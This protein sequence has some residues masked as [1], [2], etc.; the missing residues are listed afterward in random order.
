[1]I[2]DWMRQPDAGTLTGASG[3]R[4]GDYLD[5]T[6]RQARET[7]KHV[8]FLEEWATQEGLLQGLDPRAK[9]L[10]GVA[11]ILI[12]TLS[13]RQPAVWSVS[14]LALV[15]AVVSRLPARVFLQ[16]VWLSVPL[17]TGLIVLPATLNL[18]TPGPAVLVLFR[19]TG[20]SL[21]AWRL[22][23]LVAIT[24][25]GLD[26]AALVVGRAGA[27]VS[28]VV[29]VTLTTR[30]PDLLRAFRDL[31]VS[32]IFVMIIE[33][34]HRYA[35][36]LVSM[37]EDVHKAKRSRTIAVSASKRERA[38]VGSRM[39]AMLLRSRKL[40]DDVYSAMLSRG[41]DGQARALVAPAMGV[42]DWLFVSGS[43]VLCFVVLA[44]D[45]FGGS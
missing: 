21:G 12:A 37:L 42:R 7:V 43:L 20:L 24:R 14:V 36:V 31:R 35:F 45:R 15:L 44:I 1:M 4:R 16:R 5:R 22:P 3:R 17:F 25:P 19:T 32:P 13:H 27:C 18:V 6:L 41:Y 40:T 28:V 38:W 10:A 33:M 8:L 2:P 11:L 34:A 30:W 9:L 39:G 26:A 23:A 29:L